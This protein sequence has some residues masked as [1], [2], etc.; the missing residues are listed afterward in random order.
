ML[1]NRANVLSPRIEP[2]AQTQ[3]ERSSQRLWLFFWETLEDV[4]GHLGIM[5]RHCYNLCVLNVL[6]YVFFPNLCL[7]LIF[8]RTYIPGYR[9]DVGL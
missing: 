7:F 6:A 3:L 1:Y 9:P 4:L 5:G 8:N 2:V